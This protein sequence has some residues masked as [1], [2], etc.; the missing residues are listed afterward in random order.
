MGVSDLLQGVPIADL[1]P[2]VVSAA[3]DQVRA[4]CG[5]HVAPT[6]TETITLSWS[7]AGHYLLP[8]LKVWS[9]SSVTCA[10]LP[11]KFD[12]TPWGGLW[13]SGTA[14]PA[15]GSRMRAVEVTL[16]HGYATCPEDV[17][18]VVSR[19]ARESSKR[20]ARSETAGPFATVYVE[21]E[22][23]LDLAPYRL[24]AVA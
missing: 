14:S 8:S 2:I 11:V 4:I 5:W 19:L 18:A 17:R 24:P 21:D 3:A 13:V 10:G 7:P 20:R 15:F 22:T 1:D 23:D 16:M 9:V 12:W 6:V